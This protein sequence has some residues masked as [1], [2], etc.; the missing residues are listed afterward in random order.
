[1]FRYDPPS[2][3]PSTEQVEATTT[4]DKTIVDEESNTA[5]AAVATQADR[6]SHDNI[7]NDQDVDTKHSQ[8]NRY[9]PTRLLFPVNEPV[10]FQDEEPTEEEKRQFRI[11]RRFCMF[12]VMSVAAILVSAIVFGNGS[13]PQGLSTLRPSTPTIL[14]NN[15]TEPMFATDLQHQHPDDNRN[16]HGENVKM[17]SDTDSALMEGRNVDHY[18]DGND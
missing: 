9:P 17:G 16:N 15:R 7:D 12:G 1:M 4:V 3:S 13:T 8:T 5:T 11:R 2:L 14:H 18:G 6:A 10:V